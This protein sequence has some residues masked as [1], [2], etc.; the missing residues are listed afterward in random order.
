MEY[1]D[2]RRM[3][4]KITGAYNENITGVRVVKSLRREEANLDEFQDLTRPCTGPGSGPA[5]LSALFLPVVQL[6]S[7]VAI[8]GIVLYGGWQFQL[9]GMTIGGIQGLHLLHYLHAFPHPGDGAHL[10]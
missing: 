10:R 9:G 7:A 4:S 1:R 2:V 8:S 5:W 6:I 3:N